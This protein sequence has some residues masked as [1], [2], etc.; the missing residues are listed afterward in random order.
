MLWGQRRPQS[1][2]IS[3]AVVNTPSEGAGVAMTHSYLCAN[4]ASRNVL[5]YES[6]VLCLLV[7]LV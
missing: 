2:D 6:P 4:L 5:Y 1:G 7:R 3:P